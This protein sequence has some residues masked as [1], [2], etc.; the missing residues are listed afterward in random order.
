MHLVF[1]YNLT[2]QRKS[3]PL[4]SVF[5]KLSSNTS[6][7]QRYIY[8]FHLFQTVTSTLRRKKPYRF[9]QRFYLGE[10]Y[11]LIYISTRILHQKMQSA[12][13]SV[14]ITFDPI[15]CWITTSLQLYKCLLIDLSLPIYTKKQY[16][17][18]QFNLNF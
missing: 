2:R 12:F 15:L 17:A 18:K 7:R 8:S 10:R 14:V 4:Q 9:L 16:K 5:Q 6:I 13:K 3:F 1:K 11:Q